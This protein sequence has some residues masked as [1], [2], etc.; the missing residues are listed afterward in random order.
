[1]TVL[2]LLIFIINPDETILIH[3]NKATKKKRVY[4]II[5]LLSLFKNILYYEIC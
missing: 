5:F 3:L 4:I 1:M 2:A